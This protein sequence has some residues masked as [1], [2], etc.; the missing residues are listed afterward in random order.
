M[1][2]KD[3]IIAA[4][5]AAREVEP[6]APEVE[7]VETAPAAYTPQELSPQGAYVGMA[8]RFKRRVSEE[9]TNSN[10]EL[11]ELICNLEATTNLLRA[12]NSA[13]QARRKQ[14]ELFVAMQGLTHP[15]QET[16]SQEC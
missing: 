5:R 12:A 1:P 4:E 13:A 8:D 15:G 16:P 9:L 6:E 11:D 14:L 2:R 3:N 10:R 7:I